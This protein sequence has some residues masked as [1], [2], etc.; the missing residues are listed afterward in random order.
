MTFAKLFDRPEYGQ[1]LV[2][3]DA[4]DESGEP[5]LQWS[6]SPPG[7]GVCTVRLGFADSDEGWDAAEDALAK[8]DETAADR[9]AQGIFSMVG[10]EPAQG[11]KT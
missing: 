8:A 3:L 4:N 11:G 7:L 9:M 5:E 6:V 2:V 10:I 1:V